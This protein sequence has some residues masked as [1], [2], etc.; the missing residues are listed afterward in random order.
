MLFR[1]KKGDLSLSITAIV[2]IVIAFVVLGLS[3]T[4]TRAIFKGAGQ[5]LPQAL[6]LTELESKP[7]NENTI[8]I[9][10]EVEIRRGEE[11]KTMSIGYY[12]KNEFVAKGAKFYISECSKGTEKYDQNSPQLPTVVSIPQ[13]V[14]PSG[15]VGYNV[16]ITEKELFAGKYICKIE[17]RCEPTAIPS[18]ESCPVN[19]IYDEKQFFLNV[20]A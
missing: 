8:T 4:L 13:N 19:I 14:E 18:G 15:S 7:T 11:D 10:Q 9:P 6:A 3:L 17:V 1:N 20:I 2:I 12:N 5:K 16:I